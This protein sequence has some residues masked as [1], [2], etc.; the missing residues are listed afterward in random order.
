MLRPDMPIHV[1]GIGQPASIRR[2]VAAGATSSDSS[3]YARTAV[4]GR[5]WLRPEAS[6]EEPALGEA[7]QLALEHLDALC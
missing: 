1:F 4:R 3:A 6:I 2:L 7:L 5:S